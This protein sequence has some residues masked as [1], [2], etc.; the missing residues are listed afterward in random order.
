MYEG[1]EGPVDA[2]LIWKAI[3]HLPCDQVQPAPS[4]IIDAPLQPPAAAPS[5]AQPQ[6]QAAGPPSTG[7]K[8]PF[9]TSQEVAVNRG[10]A[11]HP[12]A[13]VLAVSLV[14]HSMRILQRHVLP[15][16]SQP[17]NE[18]AVA[19]TPETALPILPPGT[20]RALHS[21]GQL[22]LEH[23]EFGKVT[24][25]AAPA[26]D[27]QTAADKAVTTAAPVTPLSTLD[28]PN[29]PLGPQD[30]LASP[31]APSPLL[32]P[33]APCH[34]DGSPKPNP[35]P[36]PSA[37]VPAAQVP[38]PQCA[39]T[40]LLPVIHQHTPDGNLC[41]A[42]MQPEMVRNCCPP[43]LPSASGMIDGDKPVQRGVA[44]VPYQPAASPPQSL[45]DHQLCQDCP[46]SA[47]R[48]R[49]SGSIMLALQ[50]AGAGSSG[51]VSQQQPQLSSA[52]SGGSITAEASARVHGPIRRQGSRKPLLQ[53]VQVSSTTP[54]NCSD[55][56]TPNAGSFSFSCCDPLF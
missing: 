47:K 32:L 43:A 5:A 39:P 9:W 54:R 7:P 29:L 31:S 20:A 42:Y 16:A 3:G 2:E 8:Q 44:I 55:L 26:M 49:C 11:A 15:R 40:V 18:H 41:Q 22:Q 50:G 28:Q 25:S 52:A 34:R 12:L 10:P 45:P 33:P 24:G 30:V 1:P 27:Q 19:T 46:A 35:P 53:Q 14:L 21:S 48:Q 23:G 51:S 38:P 4:A 36:V 17:A 13:N 6:S 37:S 56:L